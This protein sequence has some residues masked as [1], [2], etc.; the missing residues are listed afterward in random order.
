[1]DGIRIHSLKQFYILNYSVFNNSVHFVIF[2]RFG[3][4]RSDDD[5]GR[6][7]FVK[8]FSR[9]KIYSKNAME[10]HYIMLSEYSFRD[11]KII[12]KMVCSYIVG[13]INRD[14][15]ISDQNGQNKKRKEKILSLPLHKSKS[16]D[17][18]PK[19]FTPSR[20]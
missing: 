12:S 2:I 18:C 13:W 16:C 14:A 9:Q 5:E 3:A 1:M 7:K 6:V 11:R 8:I 4:E 17:F 15:I 19:L 20:D 10:L